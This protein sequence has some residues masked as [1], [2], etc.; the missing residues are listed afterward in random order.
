MA[1]VCPGMC[2]SDLSF[3][4]STNRQCKQTLQSSCQPAIMKDNVN[5]YSKARPR[6]WSTLMEGLPPPRCQSTKLKVRLKESGQEAP[7][8]HACCLHAATLSSMNRHTSDTRLGLAL[9]LFATCIYTRVQG[10]LPLSIYGTTTPELR[11]RPASVNDFVIDKKDCPQLSTFPTFC[12]YGDQG[13]STP[14]PAG[15][16]VYA[17]ATMTNGLA[18]Q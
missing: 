9:S 2:Y 18:T 16:R 13:A 3:L 8:A 12:V 11:G 7:C 5:I 17:M 14:S 15:L 4:S 6:R 10:Q 1:V